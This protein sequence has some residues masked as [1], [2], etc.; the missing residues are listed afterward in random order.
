MAACGA[1]FHQSC[2][3][4]SHT[5]DVHPR[6]GCIKCGVTDNNIIQ[7]LHKNDCEDNETVQQLITLR[8]CVGSTPIVVLD[9][10]DEDTQDGGTIVVD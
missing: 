3:T 1:T 7:T 10:D 4:S 5:V 9:S 6:D 2:L 8:T